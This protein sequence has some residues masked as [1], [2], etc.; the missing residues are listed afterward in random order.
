[1]KNRT[2]RPLELGFLLPALL[3]CFFFLDAS[4]RLLPA[5]WFT[6]RPQEALGRF[7][8]GEGPYIPGR[9]LYMPATYGD[10]ANLGNL[11]AYREYHSQLASSDAFGYR[12]P[13]ALMS[14]GNVE[15]F[16]LGDS[17]SLG[18]SLNDEET[19]SAC[20]NRMGFARVYNMAGQDEIRPLPQVLAMARRLR[21]PGGIVVYQH[22]ERKP[23]PAAETLLSGPATQSG[24]FP[25]IRRL[26][27]VAARDL[28]YYSPVK[29]VCQRIQRALQN[30]RIFPNPYRDQV[31]V[32]P[33]R[34]GRPMLFPAADVH[35]DAPRPRDTT[36]FVRFAQALRQ[37]GFTL[38]VLLVPNKY[39]VYRPL[40][41]EPTAA[42]SVSPLTEIQE[43]LQRAGIAVVNPLPALQQAA[44]EAL[45]RGRLVYW[46]DDTHWNAEGSRLTARL[47]AEA[48]AAPLARARLKN[49]KGPEDEAPGPVPQVSRFSLPSQQT[50]Q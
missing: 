4:S 7:P 31:V 36:G 40:L 5:A 47:L 8:L 24:A 2:I 21:S 49:T 15:V 32:L 35:G 16:L 14:G 3:G 30:D 26:L 44:R 10:L 29:I 6:F 48:L 45:S 18:T 25:R 42:A 50:T 43:S 27:R 22:L 33:L 23:T 20:L 37:H 28:R 46:Q 1:V 19:I 9:T 38:V 12:N 34:N 39:T 17:F 41:A 11:P 13:A